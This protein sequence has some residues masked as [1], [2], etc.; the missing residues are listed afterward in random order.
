MNNTSIS[1]RT[2]GF[3]WSLAIC[4]VANAVLVIVKEKSPTVMSLMKKIGG[5]QWTGHVAVIVVLFFLMGWVLTKSSGDGSEASAKKLTGIVIAGT[6][7]GAL[8][9]IGFYLFAD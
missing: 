4:S 1:Q 8:V 6:I 9:I 7:M 3:G 5:H 2:S